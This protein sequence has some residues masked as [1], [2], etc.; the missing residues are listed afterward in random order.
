MRVF[1]GFFHSL[2]L[3]MFNI[4]A[5]AQHLVNQKDYLY[6]CERRSIQQTH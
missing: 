3:T 6:I 1:G 4:V 2:D 5:R